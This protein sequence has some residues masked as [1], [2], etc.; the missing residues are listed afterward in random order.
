MIAAFLV[1]T[2]MFAF[3]VSNVCW[4][5][6]LAFYSVFQALFLRSLTTLFLL[7]LL[8]FV[9][10]AL[11]HSTLLNRSFFQQSPDWTASILPAFF[12]IIVSML[13]LTLFIYSV[14]FAPVGISGLLICCSSIFSAGLG[15]LV[16]GEALSL[17]LVLGFVV[18]IS[19][20]LLLDEWG[21]V[22][23]ASRKGIFLSLGG[24][25]CWAFANLGFKK[26]IAEMGVLP[27]SLLQELTVAFVSASMVLKNDWGKLSNIVPSRNY[28]VRL[29]LVVS[30]CTVAGICC[31]N[32]GLN[33]LPV[34]VFS[35]LVLAQ[36]VTTL[37]TARIWLNERLT[38][39]QQLGC[40]TVITGLF[41]ALYRP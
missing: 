28:P 33:K 17:F 30:C 1:L 32:I 21:D 25:I 23:K 15:W 19:G 40:A 24:A 27:F 22:K 31:S 8:G 12:W 3:G 11:P 34:V 10:R 6:I 5:P 37:L 16:N 39:R 13:G 9:I 26:H 14:Q 35:L 29:I 36:P 4:K 18:T 20:V 7:L 38:L 41:I 2:G